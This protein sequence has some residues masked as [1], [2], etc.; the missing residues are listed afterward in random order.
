MGIIMN[1]TINADVPR[2]NVA[3]NELETTI[4]R[5]IDAYS[6]APIGVI[7]PF[8]NETQTIDLVVET[9]FSNASSA[10]WKLQLVAIDDHSTDNS[11][12]ILR[13]KATELPSLQLETIEHANNFGKGAAIRS[14]LDLIRVALVV[15][16]DAD[17][18]YDPRDLIKLVERM[19]VGDC[20]VVYGS[21]CL[22]ESNNPKRWNAFAW[23][24]SLLNLLVR[25]LYGVRLTDE[26]TCYKLFRTEDLRRMD[27]QCQRFEFCPEVT[28]KAC[29]MG[30][31]IVEVPISYRPRTR[32]E[33]K[34][35]RLRDGWDA[36]KTL[37]RYRNWQEAEKSPEGPTQVSAQNVEVVNG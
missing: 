22:P 27:L 6:Q 13:Q 17:L 23:G 3:A 5:A 8:Y 15:V 14:G 12:V 29:R 34:K 36:V 33:G 4:D 20:D 35:I 11:L 21:R 30:L 10:G 1:D 37:W 9:L 19:Q 28:A 24:V 31:K 2:R 7:L 25:V 16:Q 18:E 26:A 32:A